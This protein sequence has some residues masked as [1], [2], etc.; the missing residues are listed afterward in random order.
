MEKRLDFDQELVARI[1]V[2][3]IGTFALVDVLISALSLDKNHSL[4]VLLA[5][6]GAGFSVLTLVSLKL[7]KSEAYKEAIIYFGVVAGLVIINIGNI[8]KC[9]NYLII[10]F[11]YEMGWGKPIGAILKEPEYTVSSKLGLAVTLLGILIGIVV[12]M[13][14]FFVGNMIGPLI[15]VLAIL[16]PMVFFDLMP[17]SF[18]IILCVLYIFSSS[19]LGKKG[20]PEQGSTIFISIMFVISIAVLLVMPEEKFTRNAFF[21]ETREM[22]CDVAYEQFGLNLDERPEEEELEG[23]TNISGVVG[24]ADGV[25]GQIDS[26]K[27]TG[28]KAGRLSTN[29]TGNALYILS[30]EGFFYTDNNWNFDTE[31]TIRAKYYTPT[32]YY[33]SGAWDR[34]NTNAKV[35]NYVISHI[36]DFT[37]RKVDREYS[38]T[39][40]LAYN[41]YSTITDI[42]L[43]NGTLE[44]YAC[45]AD[46][47][48]TLYLM[49]PDKRN[50][51]GWYSKERTW[52][53]NSL[54]YRDEIKNNSLGVPENTAAVIDE[55]FG[56][57]VLE[58]NAEIVKY[59]DDVK[60]YFRNNYTYSLSPGR[61]PE[62]RE[63]VGYF[64]TEGKKGYCTYF[65]SAA[66]LIFRRAGIPARYC[67]GY[68]VSDELISSGEVNKNERYRLDV[69]DSCAHAWT[70][71]FLEGFGW[72]VVDV[73]PSAGDNLA[74]ADD[75]Q[76]QENAKDTE[77]VTKPERKESEEVTTNTAKDE[78]AETGITGEIT[79]ARM[80]RIPVIVICVP[81]VLLTAILLIL[82]IVCLGRRNLYN[83][84]KNISYEKLI[85]LYEI[86]EKELAK[87]GIKRDS[88][89][90]YEDFVKQALVQKPALKNTGLEE[91][92]KN[93]LR[94]RFS[95]SKEVD[96]DDITDIINTI[97]EVREIA[98]KE[99][100][101]R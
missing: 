2:C 28:N 9:I 41:N 97:R 19:T 74:N 53:D 16:G 35:S 1:C 63:T 45:I 33:K 88:A 52:A 50:S 58:S 26:L 43:I 59:V 82:I 54:A 80:D 81:V 95:A 69:P 49:D 62:G 94:V 27:F 85:K 89:C 21:E 76:N 92:I 31:E 64:L 10:V 77:N 71:I 47:L 20:E 39:G 11:N 70:E 29:S 40:K 55:I 98:R 60:Q 32:I 56:K 61:V 12:A 91:T 65:A 90:D 37:S 30:E 87:M 42:E 8:I 22:V 48:K 18:S 67:V 7:L 73:T 96:K 3:V 38:F 93:I 83:P 25:I 24:L 86:L 13:Q 23:G 15:L 36:N 79:F 68:R 75:T 101:N 66:T 51:V 4:S 78:G 72:V 46:E 17:S 14:V 100:R 84:E 57:V 34:I 6:F 5:L 44:E 99:K